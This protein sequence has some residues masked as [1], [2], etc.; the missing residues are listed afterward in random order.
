MKRYKTLADDT[1]GWGVLETQQ[2]QGANAKQAG[3]ILGKAAVVPLDG[4]FDY[5]H[6]C[7]VV[8]GRLKQA[9]DE[10]VRRW[11][12]AQPKRVLDWNDEICR[13]SWTTK[14]GQQ[15]ESV[16]EVTLSSYQFFRH[17]EYNPR[18]LITPRDLKVSCGRARD[19]RVP[20]TR[21][22]RAQV[23]VKLRTTANFPGGG[24]GG[25]G[26][27]SARDASG[28]HKDGFGYNA[29]L[30]HFLNFIGHAA[31][32]ANINAAQ[33]SFFD[34][35]RVVKERERRVTVQRQKEDAIQAQDRET[36]LVAGRFSVG[37][38]PVAD[39]RPP[40]AKKSRVDAGTDEVGGNVA[41]AAP[42]PV[43]S[44]SADDSDAL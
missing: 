6:D 28:F 19:V 21:H 16:F 18:A 38:A 26:Q 42:R 10:L 34:Y 14:T 15:E 4:F 30:E 2:L 12:V 37:P 24:G 23:L 39:P 13:H 20:L 35:Q 33:K 1:W 40:P 3:K 32:Q 8:V 41:A 5:F 43:E 31:F 27:Q 22:H 36:A 9:A 7:E 17:N 29:P 44:D 11:N 25:G